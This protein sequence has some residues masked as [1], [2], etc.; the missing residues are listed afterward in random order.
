M[1]F[2]Q[3]R[4]HS[5]H[6]YVTNVAGITKQKLDRFKLYPKFKFKLNQDFIC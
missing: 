5:E 4:N 1:Y 3:L 2:F 6:N